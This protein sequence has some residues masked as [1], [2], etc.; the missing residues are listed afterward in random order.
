LTKYL[1]YDV[2]IFNE[3]A[4]N[5]K[6]VEGLIPSVAATCTSQEDLLYW[7]DLPCMTPDMAKNLV[8]FMLSQLEDGFIPFTWNGVAF[9]FALLAQYSGMVEECAELALNGVDGMLL[10][11]F[12]NGYFLGLDTALKGAG[13][14]S[15]THSVKLN[16]GTI[17]EEM[18]GA[19]AP[20]LWRDG[21][22][23]AVKT[24]LAGD[25]F[26]PLELISAIEKNKG[27]KWTSKSGKPN[28][29]RTNLTLVKDLFKIPAPD[30]SW[31]STSPK[32]RS[33]FVSWIPRE[34]LKKYSIE[35]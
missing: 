24:Y 11:T 13:L 17:L 15:K 18:S 19:L 30:T 31:M 9:D 2:E 23:E 6:G 10:V 16:D 25:V 4:E 32:P 8:L 26:R 29:V 21:E 34:I 35:I 20:K 27:I 14:Q 22:Y 12:P 7:Y 5:Q 33:E 1:S 28:F 3:F